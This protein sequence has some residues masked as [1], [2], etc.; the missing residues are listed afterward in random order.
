MDQPWLI[1]LATIGAL[2]L[3]TVAAWLALSGGNLDRGWLAI[4]AAL[5]I[6]RCPDMADRVRPLLEPPAQP[7]Q[8]AKPSGAPL[9]VLGL[10]QRE[11]RL[12][13]FLLEDIRNYPDEQ[14]GA[15]VR[16][17]HPHCQAALKEHLTFAPVL[18]AAEGDTVEVA[19]GFDPSAIRLTGNVTGQP[20]FRG[21]VR[22]RGWRVVEM[23]LPAPPE[24]QDE[25]V[26]MPAEVELP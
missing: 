2:L 26:L 25:F 23:K 10:L 16:D 1:V 3:L 21:I 19:A 7:S 11:G 17:I 13:D 5:R 14:I 4:R 18:D 24:G 22:H 9:R 20:P 15:A 6:M 12:V 8:P